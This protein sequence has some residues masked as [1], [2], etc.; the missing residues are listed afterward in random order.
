MLMFEREDYLFSFDLKSG[1]H[2]VDVFELHRQFLGFQWEVQ[3]LPSTSTV[4][5][6]IFRAYQSVPPNDHPCFIFMLV[7]RLQMMRGALIR[8]LHIH[9]SLMSSTVPQWPAPSASQSMSELSGRR[10]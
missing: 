8:L 1:Y 4:L 5:G 2:H 9:V 10:Q 3:G 6:C 7:G